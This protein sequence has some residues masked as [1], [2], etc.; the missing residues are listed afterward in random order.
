MEGNT[1]AQELIQQ[2]FDKRGYIFEWQTFLAQQDPSFV[3]AYEKVF[4]LVLNRQGALPSMYRE[5]IYTAV[6][7]SRGE[8]S[9]AKNHI[10]RALDLGATPQQVV[11]AVQT[12]WNPT[13]SVTLVHGI[14][15]LI[16][17]LKERGEY[18]PIAHPYRTTDG[19]K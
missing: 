11:E 7:S 19:G 16:D 3:E 17:V 12:A 10:R 13:G 9:V 18:E 6:L 5:L 2:I 15:A 14:K 4:N 8:G 1:E